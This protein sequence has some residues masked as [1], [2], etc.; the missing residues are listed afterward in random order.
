MAGLRRWMNA[1]AMI[2]PEPKYLAKLSG[3]YEKGVGRR[4]GRLTRKR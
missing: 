3:G 4:K 2:T 1:V